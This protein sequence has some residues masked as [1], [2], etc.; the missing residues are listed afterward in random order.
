MKTKDAEL[1]VEI[2]PRMKGSKVANN[3]VE[4]V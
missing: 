2:A 1:V 3:A 4:S